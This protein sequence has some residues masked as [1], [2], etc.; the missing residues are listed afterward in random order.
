MFIH[1]MVTPVPFGGAVGV[2]AFFVL[3]GFLITTILLREHDLTGRIRL[4]RFYLRR[5]IRL[6]PP[7]VLAIVV[8]F[9]PGMIFAP[10]QR[11]WLMDNLL[12]VTYTTPIG[13]DLGWTFSKA[14]GH[15]WTLGIEEM[16]YLIWP[17]LLLVLFGRFRGRLGTT[18][19][20]AAIGIVMMSTNLALELA[21]GRPSELLRAGGLFI[22]CALASALWNRVKLVLPAWL[23][24]AGLILIA[25]AVIYRTAG[26]HTTIAVI[27][28]VAG[29]VAMTLD[30]STRRAGSLHKWLAVRPMAYVGRISYELYLWHYPILVVLAWAVGGDL[31]DV[32]WIAAPLSI[33]LA[34]GAH[35]L[36]EPAVDRWKHRVS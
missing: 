23:G 32:A 19:I 25:A 3:S 30:V 22:G 10:V 27:L 16:F 31:I 24:W 36:V 12:A 11:V 26:G 1:H 18:A 28:T 21:G 7:L 29:S 15:T 20:V 13:R 14:W 33:A 5:L 17:A 8:L 35:R 9:I 34:A 6:Y 2:D 4:K